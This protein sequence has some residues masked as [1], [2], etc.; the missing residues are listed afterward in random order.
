MEML[1]KHC[2][3]KLL[4]IIAPNQT[5]LSTE[6]GTPKHFSDLKSCKAQVE[7]LLKSD[8]YPTCGG[9]A[10]R[11]QP[12]T[13]PK[14]ANKYA[15]TIQPLLT[16]ESQEPVLVDVYSVLDAFGVSNPAIAHAIKKLLMPGLRGD[17]TREQDL[18][19]A[20]VSIQRALEMEATQ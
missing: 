5:A 19:E 1:R 6:F 14:P 18:R 13:T 9:M 8:S 4:A 3:Q 12:K 15:R 7:I 2:D 16:S 17:K 10:W 20:V 11:V